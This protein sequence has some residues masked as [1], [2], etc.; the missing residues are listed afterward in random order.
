M[1]SPSFLSGIEESTFFGTTFEIGLMGGY[2]LAVGVGI[3]LDI[4]DSLT[5]SGI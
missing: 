2:D 5:S 3:L 1:L 4:S